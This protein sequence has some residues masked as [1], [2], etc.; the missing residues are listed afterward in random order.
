MWGW[1]SQ[2][3]RSSEQHVHI[4]RDRRRRERTKRLRWL[5]ERSHL[6]RSPPMFM[7]EQPS[8]TACT[9]LSVHLFPLAPCVLVPLTGPPGSYSSAALGVL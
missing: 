8:Q 1:P 6:R 5:G 3:G 4:E 7:R 9:A 2:E